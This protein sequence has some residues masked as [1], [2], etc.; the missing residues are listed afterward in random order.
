MKFNDL[1]REQVLGAPRSVPPT[2]GAGADARSLRSTASST[3]ERRE[4][5]GKAH[6]DPQLRGL[7]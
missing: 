4:R 7:A 1:R 3:R 5:G 6:K 2:P